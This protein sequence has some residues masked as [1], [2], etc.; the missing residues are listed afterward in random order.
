[1]VKLLLS[2]FNLVTNDQNVIFPDMLWYQM[3]K[4]P[5]VPICFGNKW[6]TSY[7]FSLV[8][9]GQNL[10]CPNLLWY[11]MEKISNKTQASHIF[12]FTLLVMLGIYEPTC[13]EIPALSF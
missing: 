1:M 12:F 2:Q 6:S 7:L 5:F 13:I 9:N 4:M 8:P 10:I 3:F 11:Q